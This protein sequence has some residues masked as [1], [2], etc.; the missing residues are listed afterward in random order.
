MS[1][2]AT[3]KHNELIDGSVAAHVRTLLTDAQHKKRRSHGLLSDSAFP[4]LRGD[5]EEYP[6]DDSWL[7]ALPEVLFAWLWPSSHGRAD[8]IVSP[9]TY[10]GPSFPLHAG[11]KHGLLAHTLSPA[12][13]SIALLADLGRFKRICTLQNL[14][15]DVLLAGES[16]ARLNWVVRELRL[17]R[18]LHG[19]RTMRHTLYKLAGVLPHECTA[20]TSP[21][22]ATGL[23]KLSGLAQD[24]SRLVEELFGLDMISQRLTRDMVSTITRAVPTRE[25]VRGVLS[26][27]L[28]RSTME[29]VFAVMSRVAEE[30]RRLDANT[31]HYFLLQWYHQRAFS[32]R[33]KIT[34]R[35]ERSFDEPFGLMERDTFWRD[36]VGLQTTAEPV[37][38]LYHEDYYFSRDNDGRA[39]SL[40]PYYFPSG[41]LYRHLV[42]TVA[43]EGRDVLA[44]DER[45]QILEQSRKHVPM[46]GARTENFASR[47]TQVS[48]AL[49]AMHP[50]DRARY[51]SDLLS[52]VTFGNGDVGRRVAGR[53]AGLAVEAAVE[54]WIGGETA[55]SLRLHSGL[56]DESTHARIWVR[57]CLDARLGRAAT[58]P[59]ALP[60]IWE[61]L[62][63]AEAKRESLIYYG[64]AVTVAIC[65]EVEASSSRIAL[66][67]L[68]TL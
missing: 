43:G 29:P 64:A 17:E 18:N 8:S 54:Q 25:Q 19:S 15:P 59:Q 35:R 56:Q 4:T 12:G 50:F 66:P 16:W 21:F 31:F 67:D 1:A 11:R 10:D 52:F 41:S 57:Q 5:R 58:P 53:L 23:G 27:E 45:Y 42:D 62:G 68:A 51:L 13:D 40:Q 63:D 9:S 32:D 2:G 38:A 20:E 48:A 49:S 34:I 39:L 3:P 14:T 6:L 55:A 47:T 46:L 60:F 44:D 22:D 30:L 61:L 7:A 37:L 24:L 65:E 36:T 28:L 26:I 33:L